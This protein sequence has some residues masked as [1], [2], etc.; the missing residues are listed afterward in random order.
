M[1]NQVSHFRSRLE[2]FI[3]SEVTGSILLLACTV[4]ALAWANSPWADAYF[5]LLH[6][7]V[8]VSWGTSSFS[9]SLQHWIN[10]GLMA[11]FFFVVGLEIKRELVVGRA[12][13]AR[14][15]RR[16]RSRPRSAA[17]SCRR[18]ST[19]P[20]TPAER[21]PTGWGI[22]MATDIAFALGVLALLGRRVPLGLKV[23]LTAL[24]IADDLGRGRGHRDLLHRHPQRACLADGRRVDRQPVRGDPRRRQPSAGFSTC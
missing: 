21:A 5:H 4:V 10:D 18:C 23:F 2:W 14:A 6:T 8:G 13:V 17:W 24:A 12:V 20:S 19:S 9:L 7:P 11:V 15:R 22:P 16:C 3:H 1:Q